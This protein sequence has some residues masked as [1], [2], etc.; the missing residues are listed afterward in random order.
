[1][2]RYQPYNFNNYSDSSQIETWIRQDM[3]EAKFELKG[4]QVMRDKEM[5]DYWKQVVEYFQRYLT[6]NINI[7]QLKKD[8]KFGNESEQYAAGK[9]LIKLGIK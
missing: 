2:N 7:D 9:I 8:F 6:N 4:Y 5:I 3:Q 1:M